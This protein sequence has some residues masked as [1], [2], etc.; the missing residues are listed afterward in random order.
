MRRGE[1][2]HVSRPLSQTKGR[3]ARADI[4]GEPIALGNDFILK[5][6][7]RPDDVTTCIGRIFPVLMG[8]YGECSP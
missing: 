6:G 7:D 1:P 4:D 8:I 3:V 2:P 5:N